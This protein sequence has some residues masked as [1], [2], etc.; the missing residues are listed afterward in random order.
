MRRILI[1]GSRPPDRSKL[2]IEGQRAWAALETRCANFVTELGPHV[3][4]VTGGAYG[5]D[6]VAEEAAA[7]ALIHCAVVRVPP[8]AWRKVG[9][10]AGIIR[11]S[12]M[13]NLC[14]EVAVFRFNGSAGSTYVLEAARAADKL[15]HID[16]VV[17]R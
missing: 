5:I 8:A 6:R 2:S 9:K 3:L 10:K 13:L 17:A 1:A 16:D 4:V 15:T 12:I 14:E 11:D 7:K